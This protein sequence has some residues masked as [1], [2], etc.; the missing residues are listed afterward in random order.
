MNKKLEIIQVIFKS[1]IKYIESTW[2]NN[3][4]Q[5]ILNKYWIIKLKK[6]KIKK[7]KKKQVQVNLLDPG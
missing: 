1:T 2:K 6:H 7:R 3:G 4:A 5:F